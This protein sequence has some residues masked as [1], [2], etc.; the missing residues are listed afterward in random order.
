M[1][2][3]EGPKAA[4]DESAAA[5]TSPRLLPRDMMVLIN[6]KCKVL[7]SDRK[8]RKPP[9]DLAGKVLRV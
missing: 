7:S 1:Q 8:G 5:D 3:D 4:P 2:V 6:D 9:S